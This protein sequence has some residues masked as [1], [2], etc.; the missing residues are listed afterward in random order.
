M[1]NF[2][3]TIRMGAN[4]N[5]VEVTRVG[6]KTLVFDRA[7]MR[8][9]ALETRD[10]SALDQVRH[11]IVAMFEDEYERNMRKEH[12]R[13][14]RANKQAKRERSQKRQYSNAVAA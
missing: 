7:E 13:R 14:K 8:K 2:S 12:V 1:K 11:G 10:F 5:S 3:A 6:H 9:V 4:V